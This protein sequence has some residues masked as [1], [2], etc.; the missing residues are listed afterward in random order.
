VHI[1]LGDAADQALAPTTTQ[2]VCDAVFISGVALSVGYAFL[3]SRGGSFLI[4]AL[5]ARPL[6]KQFDPLE[7]LFAWELEKD[8]RRA[9]GEPWEEDDDPE[10]L[11]SLVDG[12]GPAL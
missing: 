3:S 9:Q 11:Q 1:R 5:T 12:S 2:K 7:V 10:T 4:S 8:R 6:W